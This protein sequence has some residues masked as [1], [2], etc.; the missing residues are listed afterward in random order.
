[1][2]ALQIFHT[3]AAILWLGNFAVT[4]VWS[5]RAFASR[6]RVLRAFA[7]REIL[8][9]DVVFVLLGAIAVVGS[10]MALAGMEH[11]PVWSTLWTRDAILTV[12][13]GGIVWLAVLLPLEFRMREQALRANDALDRTFTMWSVAG[14]AVTIALFSVVFLMLAKPV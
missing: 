12:A 10:G 1:M 14:I 7:T 11:V 6:D 2:L 3:V 9:T 8:F 5:A 13:A 4:G